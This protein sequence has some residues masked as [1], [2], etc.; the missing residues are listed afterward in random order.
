MQTFQWNIADILAAHPDL[1]LEHCVVMAVALMSNWSASP[2]E[3]LVECEGFSPPA[4]QGESSFLVHVTWS[5][6]TSVTAARI[7]HTE[8]P[9]PIL[10]RAAVALAALLFA[11]LIPDGQMRVTEQGQRADYWLPSCN[12]P[13]KSAA[14]NTA[15]KCACIEKVGGQFLNGDL[16]PIQLAWME[17]TMEC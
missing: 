10:E 4:L 7:W 8:Q 17:L 3:F 11:H 16:S 6:Q 9:K 12:V 15:G 1:Y 5:E 13:W 2:C 14:R